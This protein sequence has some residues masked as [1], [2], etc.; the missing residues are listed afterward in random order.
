MK[1]RMICNAAQT[2]IYGNADVPPCL[3]GH[4]S[5]WSKRAGC[6]N[7]VP[8]ECSVFCCT[9]GCTYAEDYGNRKCIEVKDEK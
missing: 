9:G 6:I 7:S 5:G 3:A 8:H 2:C 1:K 4:W